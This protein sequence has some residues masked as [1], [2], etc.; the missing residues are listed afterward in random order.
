MVERI[1]LLCEK[2]N[3]TLKQLERDLGMGNG[4][5]A[6]SA[7]TMRSDR[8]K[9][10]ADY[11]GVSMEY[12]MTGS[13]SS[14][15]DD[16]YYLNRETKEIAQEVFENPDTRMLFDAA[17]DARPEDIKLAAEMLKRMKGIDD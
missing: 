16:G 1:R 3:T 11:F 9:A 2:N 13:D 17:R 14:S 10:I 12:L 4:T 5:I 7:P 6:K 15:S 8:L